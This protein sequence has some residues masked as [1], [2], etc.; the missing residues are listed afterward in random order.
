MQEGGNA[1]I[2]LEGV[3][4]DDDQ[5]D[6]VA[7]Y[8]AA[9]S[10]EGV[11]I[12]RI[13]NDGISL[14]L[15]ARTSGSA[16]ITITGVDTR[17]GS[18]TT[19]FPVTVTRNEPPIKRPNRDIGSLE[20]NRIEPMSIDLNDYYTD[21][22]AGDV[23]TFQ[24]FSSSPTIVFV[25][26][27]ESILT[28]DGRNVGT[29]QISLSISDGNNPA[30]REFISVRVVNLPPTTV[31][32]IEDVTTV[33]GAV[34]TIELAGFFNDSDNDSLTY[35]ATARKRD[36][37]R[38][39]VTGST[40][41]I[42]GEA[43]DSAVID[44]VAR[45][46]HGGE[47]TSSVLVIVENRVPVVAN[48]I[49]SQMLTRSEEINLRITTVFTDADEDSLTYSIEVEDSGIVEATLN[50]N[51]IRLVGSAV[52]ET[53]VTL[54]A[55][56]SYNTVSTDFAVTVNN[57][58]P[59]VVMQIADATTHRNQSI[60]LD[61]TKSF[62]D[63]DGDDLQYSVSVGKPT[64]VSAEVDTDGMLTV[65]GLSLG[66]SIVT[67][68]ATDQ[69]DDAA[70]ATFIVTVENIAPKVVMEIDDQSSY[71][72]GTFS[73]D[74]STV[75]M[76]EDG[77]PLTFSASSDDT[78]VASTSVT[79]SM[80]T[81]TG[82]GVGSAQI[83]VSAMDEFEGSA[84]TDFMIEIENRAPEAVGS[85]AQQSTN[86]NVD[87]SF[88]LQPFFTDVDNDLLTYTAVSSD[89]TVASVTVNQEMITLTGQMVGSVQV[90]VTAT[91]PYDATATQEFTTEVLNLAPMTTRELANVTTDRTKTETVDL[92]GLFSDADNDELTLSVAVEDTDIATATLSELTLTIDPEN[93][94]ATTVT[95]TAVDQFD[96]SASTSFQV[97]VQ[98]LQPSIGD[99]LPE[100][101]LQVGGES[102]QID[103]TAAFTDDGGT[104]TYSVVVGTEEIATA[105]VE[106]TTVTVSPVSTGITAVT[107]TATDPE[108]LS[109]MQVARVT[110]SDSELKAVAN[111][112]LA[113]FSKA[114][115]SS[116]SSS[117]G[118]RLLADADGLYAPL[119]TL[120]LSDL[121]SN[122]DNA[123]VA[124]SLY[125][126]QPFGTSEPWGNEVAPSNMTAQSY[127]A[128][129]IRSF[130]EQGVALQFGAVGDPNF[131]SVW[132]AVDRQSFQSDLGGYEGNATSFYFGGDYTLQG[133]MMFGLGIGRSSGESDYTFGTATQT[134]DMS[135]TSIL[136]YARFAPSDRTTIYGTFGVG[137]GEIETTVVGKNNH[138]SDLSASI[139]LFGG[140]QY[141]W[142]TNAGMD[143]AVVGDFGFVNLETDE[144]DFAADGL[145]AET[146]RVRGGVEASWNLA[147]GADGSFIPFFNLRF[148]SDSGDG[149]AD[150]GLEIAGGLR[151]ANPVFSVDVNFRTLAT[152]GIDDYSESGFSA[153]AV[154]NPMAGATGL[155]IS[156][157]PRWGAEAKSTD[158]LWQDNTPIG[159]LHRYARWGH[160]D[161][162]MSLESKIGYGFLMQG[163]QLLLTP[164]VDLTSDDMGYQRVNLGA[165]L[166]PF[167][168]R[169]YSF[170]IDV[171]LGLKSNEQLQSQETARLRARL[172]F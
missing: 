154:L 146:S 27:A 42:T 21:P 156:L 96:D 110:V 102:G 18:A 166:T 8:Q 2:S 16:T 123:V 29:S 66:S 91:D 30:L 7:S 90:V 105:S 108:G 36:V 95:I 85:I 138:Q 162:T 158:I 84:N 9:S 94:G 98:N 6:S 126:E 83:S 40:L 103:V 120:Y 135:L 92:T 122:N 41:R 129:Y 131:F 77:D 72:T 127:S 80:L 89:A 67:L 88:S 144:G 34:T 24:A 163:D 142:G 128:D 79:E 97:I 125:A 11:V 139:G 151:I 143:L 23:L 37:V 160:N 1:T 112:A 93:L 51:S 10:N 39:R 33:R 69:F 61:L 44:I 133:T 62:E 35:S 115:L 53:I 116:V 22:D 153:M 164:F 168:K 114:V 101:M 109:N 150:S 124:S 3:F 141:V 74:L 113:G 170:D 19:T 50:T 58:A 38:T 5:G 76:D 49:S 32:D 147:M 31:G 107:V 172:N 87:V 56:D 48:E 65:T 167:V 111:L 171:L 165:K 148:R 157:A 86:R 104:L 47:A 99:A 106:G 13:L 26:V 54:T 152:Y 75:F 28:L 4:V 71:R 132:G 118:S 70:M 119:N 25:S 137:S 15:I 81:V 59:K 117:V 134:M 130:L 145:V 100:L 20:I 73:V 60:M 140:R 14:T 136:P 169:D 78:S 149:E 68:T 17:G 121:R 55:D 159:G 52:G 46:A 57:I 12:A 161:A 64:I 63:D 155:K 82:N 43:V 45:D